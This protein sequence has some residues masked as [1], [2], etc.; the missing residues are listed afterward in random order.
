MSVDRIFFLNADKEVAYRFDR[1]DDDMKCDIQCYAPLK[2]LFVL[3]GKMICDYR[4]I[5]NSA[6]LIKNLSC[7]SYKILIQGHFG[8]CYETRVYDMLRCLEPIGEF[9]EIINPKTD[10]VYKTILIRGVL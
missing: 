9:L 5:R 3:G 4:Y 8:K 1:A 10:E 7:G 6:S 2:E